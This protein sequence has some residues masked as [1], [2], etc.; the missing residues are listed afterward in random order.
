MIY[1]SQSNILVLMLLEERIHVCYLGLNLIL[2]IYPK[3]SGF[4]PDARRL[5]N[6]CSF[7]KGKRAK[8]VVVRGQCV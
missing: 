3:S 6:H 4:S 2:Q 1:D 7:I 5:R 8:R